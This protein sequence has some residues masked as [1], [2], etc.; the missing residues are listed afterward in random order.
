MAGATS[1]GSTAV[2]LPPGTAAGSWY[3]IAQADGEGAVTEVSEANN[4][5]TLAVK[6]GPDL[7]VSALSVPATGGA[8][9]TITITDTTKNQSG[10]AAG[11]SVTRFYLSADAALGASDVLIG[12]RAVPALTAG[13]TSSGSTTV[14]IPQGTAAG[15][16]SIIAQADG[17]EAVTEISETNNTIS[18]PIQLGPDLDITALSAP[19]SSGAGQMI[20][21]LDTTKNAGGEPTGPSR[22]DFYLSA[23]GTL[24][25]SDIFL[26]SRDLPSL[27]AGATDS[28]ATSITI[29]LGTAVGNWSLIAKAD[30]GGNVTEVSESNNTFVRTIQIGPDLT[31]AALSA[32]ASATGG[33][34][35]V[36][37]DTTKNQGGDA[38][39]PSRTL[40]Y[41]SADTALD[42]SDILL[43]SRDVPSLA[44]GTAG[45][46]STSVTIPQGTAVRTW[47]IIAKADGE[48]TVAETLETNNVTAKALKVI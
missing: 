38:A 30:A 31:I 7:A 43:G 20:V 22:T 46:G 25:A 42:A 35:I 14:V 36:I 16:W 45:S 47:Y 39:G 12:S 26:G 3:I 34:A 9:Q 37:G 23:D 8:G 32:P 21:L 19:G 5:A 1:A 2:T 40:F 6:V 48:G 10:D 11:P 15:S 13:T 44:A 41:L 17:E 4:T 28:G 24:G 18:R 29:P 27:A 33:Q